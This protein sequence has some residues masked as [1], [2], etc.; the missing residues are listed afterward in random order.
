M[1][2][3]VLGLI[4][5]LNPFH[6]GHSYFIHQAR[7]KVNPDLTVAIITTSFT[8][9]G[10]ISVMDKFEKAKL[11]LEQDVDL[12]L[13]LPFV[14]SNNSASYFASSA[15][16]ILNN[17]NIT[18]L[19]FGAELDDI[20]K[21]Q[22][23]ERIQSSATFNENTKKYLDKGNSYPTS[24]LKS[25]MEETSDQELINNYPLSNNT[26]AINYLSA[27]KKINDKITPI[28]IKRIDND[29]NSKDVKE[30]TLASATA[31]REI[32]K[33]K[34]DISSYIPNYN[35]DFIDI[36]KSYDNLYKLLK[37]NL[38][39]SDVTNYANVVEGIENR[40]LSFINDDNYEDFIKDVNT[41]RYS[42]SRIKRIIL[43]IVLNI[44]KKYQDM[45]TYLPYNRILASSPLGL[46]HLKDKDVINNTKQFLENGN[47]ELKEILEY[48]LKVTK[49]YDLITNKDSFKNE[50]IFMVKK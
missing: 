25:L 11:L 3:K 9:R 44:P 2:K 16:S 45:N 38:L 19:A 18:H 12:V 28:V 49:L 22:T 50:F 13:E 31:L 33:L 48:E 6:N 8:M 14:F 47:E 24:S 20:S 36:D 23:L 43:D 30:N 15:V 26:L 39:T 40:F 7:E 29:Y 1:N 4:L 10:D 21:L 35:Y 46:K 17:M 34:E 32:I 5:E 27:I 37:Y 42:T 41:K